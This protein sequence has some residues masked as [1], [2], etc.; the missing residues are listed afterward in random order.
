N[1]SGDNPPHALAKRRYEEI[2]PDDFLCTHEHPSE[3]AP[4]PV[5]FQVTENGLEYVQPT[6]EAEEK[7]STLTEAVAKA[8][9]ASEPPATRVGFGCW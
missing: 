5:V 3:E 4:E 6:G 9:G 1:K 2:V 8:R 7:Q